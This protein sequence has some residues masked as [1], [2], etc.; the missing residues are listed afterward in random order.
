MRH[1]KSAWDTDA[2]TDHDRPLNERGRRDA[3]RIAA[4]MTTL[5]WSPDLTVSSDSRRTRQTFELMRGAFAGELQVRFTR[6]LYHAGLDA[7][8][9]ALADVDDAVRTVMVVGHNPGWEDMLER[10]CGQ[11]LR[12]TTANAALLTIDA[13]SWAHALRRDTW[14]LTRLLRPKEL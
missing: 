12:L 9:H 5:G 4:T 10:L 6:G 1:A 8:Q 11:A 2:A 3:P 14:T 7:V 13:G